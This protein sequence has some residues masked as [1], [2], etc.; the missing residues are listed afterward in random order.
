VGGSVDLILAS[1]IGPCK[2][3]ASLNIEDR[4]GQIL[5]KRLC[6]H[7]TDISYDLL[8]S[9]M[10]RMHRTGERRREEYRQCQQG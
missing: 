6:V 8:G 1:I 9:A 7:E 3:I 10:Y 2:L 4:T 5:T